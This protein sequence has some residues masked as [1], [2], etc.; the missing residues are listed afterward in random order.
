[1]LF[2]MDPLSQEGGSFC[3]WG[4]EMGGV[5]RVLSFELKL[6]WDEGFRLM[7]RG[8]AETVCRTPVRRHRR[9]C[10]A[11]ECRIDRQINGSWYAY[12]GRAAT[13]S[14]TPVAGRRKGSG[15]AALPKAF[16]FTQEMKAIEDVI[17]EY[18]NIDTDRTYVGGCSM[19]GAGTVSMVTAYP[20]F[21]AAAF[22]I[23]AVGTFDEETAQKPA[24]NGMPVYLIPL[25]R[26]HHRQ[27]LQQRLHVRAA[28]QCRRGGPPDPVRAF[29]CARRAGGDLPDARPLEL[30]CVHRSFDCEGEYVDS[31]VAPPG[32][33]TASLWT[34]TS[35]T[36]LQRASTAWTTAIQLYG[37]KR[38]FGGVITEAPLS[39][40]CH[41]L[42][43]TPQFHR[44][45]GDAPPAR[46]DVSRRTGGRRYGAP[47]VGCHN[48]V[49]LY[50]APINHSS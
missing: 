41:Q 34:T 6:V 30:G 24:E 38:E 25:H 17:A 11:C 36:P 32:S 33:I 37:H 35:S 20:D 7:I 31:G 27:R 21:F 26:R 49:F 39:G 15:D 43:Q 2:K 42:K 44:R 5:R 29:H 10:C 45:G 13:S 23:C 12:T 3:G 19:G 16:T 14:D 50:Y 18:G 40:Q 48:R 46:P 28:H 47:T 8:D 4:G 9:R 22:P 1:M